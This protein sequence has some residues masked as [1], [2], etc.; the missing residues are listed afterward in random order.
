MFK[1]KQKRKDMKTLKLLVAVVALAV[2]FGA[3][4]KENDIIPNGGNVAGDVVYANQFDRTAE[5]TSNGSIS[6]VG[7]ELCIEHHFHGEYVTLNNIWNDEGLWHG[8]GSL[9]DGEPG[10][11][12]SFGDFHVKALNGAFAGEEYSSFCSHYVSRALGGDKGISY[13]DKTGLRFQAPY[14]TNKG[15]I[16]AVLSFIFDTWG[17]VDQWP[18]TSS[19]TGLRSATKLIAQ[20]ALWDLL[21]EGVSGVKVVNY[22]DHQ[23]LDQNFLDQIN[24]AIDLAITKTNYVSPALTTPNATTITDIVFLARDQYEGIDAEK[25]KVYD[26]RFNESGL[27]ECQPQMVPL[28][29][30]TPETKILGPAYGSVTAINKTPTALGNISIA[31]VLGSFNQKNGN[32][33]FPQSYLAGVVYNANHFCYARYTRAELGAGVVLDMV[34]GNKIDRVG[35]ATAQ[36]VG[37]NIEV[38]IENFGK[39]DF[40]VM[41]FNKPMTSNMPKNGNIHSQKA[42]DLTSQLGATTGFNHDNKL[43]VPCPTGNDIYLY[44]HCGTIQFWQ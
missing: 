20:A 43:V 37:N 26:R 15:E 34:V 19:K 3:C 33:Q 22:P 4:K 32:A 38:V 41:A 30:T 31:A 36:I 27:L 14:Q 11:N 42:A 5:Y 28:K 16:I 13:W 9:V 1:Q 21:H 8:Q 24:N 10:V 17:S 12:H 29:G 6:Y 18:T 44:I 25:Q 7:G 39:G 2:A 40:G 35:K 23:V